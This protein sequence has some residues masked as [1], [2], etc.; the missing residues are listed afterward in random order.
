MDDIL[1]FRNV[2]GHF[3]TGV[4]VVTA[5]HNGE[6]FGLTVNSFTSISLDPMLILV[7]IAKHTS[8][9]DALIA[10]G[11]FAVSLLTKKQEMIST[12]FAGAPS[13]QRFELI[14]I[15]ESPEGIP[16]IKDSLAYCIAEIIHIHDAGDHSILISKVI[17]TAFLETDEAP[18]VFYRGKYATLK[19]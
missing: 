13:A 3:P 10:A 9:H 6:K 11:I 4:T 7:S 16:V 12:I 2:M 14:N 18:L 8:S 15:L 19:L 1:K 5:I 17:R